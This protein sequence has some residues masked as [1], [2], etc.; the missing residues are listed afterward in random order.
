M[1]HAPELCS[2]AVDPIA[3][4]FVCP[5]CGAGVDPGARRCAHC[6][7]PVATVRCA[8]CFAMNAPDSAYCSGCGRDLGLEP[9]PRPGTLSCPDCRETMS[10]LDCGP[11][12]VHDC[13][14]CG[15]QFVDNAGLRDLVE[16]HDRLDVGLGGRQGARA[17]VETW[18]RYLRCPVCA[19][20]MN[21]R[22]FAGAS[23]VVV[24]V[25]AKH[26]TWFDAGELPRILT[27]VEA[28]GLTRARARAAEQQRVEAVRERMGDTSKSYALPHPDDASG[29]LSVGSALVDF[30]RELF[31]P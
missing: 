4:R 6:D 5:G 17:P 20:M 29:V 28:G 22:N 12:V 27:F 18:V 23:G 14:R 3:R 26:G 9:I 25:C 1:T 30:L 11:G 31:E 24:D 2:G 21:R 15:G 8:S 19:S 10:G 16:R 7:G 13:G